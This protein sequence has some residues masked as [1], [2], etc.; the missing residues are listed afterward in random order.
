MTAVLLTLPPVRWVCPNCPV[1]AVTPGNVPNR[2][3]DCRAL[4]GITAPM[5]PAGSGARVFTLERED[6]EG[7]E[8]VQRDGNGRPIMAVVTERPDGSNDVAVLA[9]TARMTA[10]GMM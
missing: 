7:R 1:E 4:A 3:H 10:E 8:I 9:P 6:Y 5:V 2:Y